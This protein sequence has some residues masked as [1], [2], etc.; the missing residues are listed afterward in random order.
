MTTANLARLAMHSLG[1]IL[2]LRKKN[3]WWMGSSDAYNCTSNYINKQFL[4]QFGLV[5]SKMVKTMLT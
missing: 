4:A 5:G 3:G 2:L 1:A